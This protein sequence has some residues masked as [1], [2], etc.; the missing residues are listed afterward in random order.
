MLN[1]NIARKI[2]EMF[3]N[4][5]RDDSRLVEALKVFNISKSKMNFFKGEARKATGRFP[6]NII[7]SPISPSSQ[8]RA[9]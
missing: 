5:G 1:K 4:T 2:V 9:R 8:N 3:W 6:R 7:L